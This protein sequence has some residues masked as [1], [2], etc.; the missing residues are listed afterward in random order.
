MLIDLLA[1]GLGILVVTM[2]ILAMGQLEQGIGHCFVLIKL[3]PLELLG[4]RD[5]VENKLEF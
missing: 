3:L 1:M 5:L 2:S 4:E